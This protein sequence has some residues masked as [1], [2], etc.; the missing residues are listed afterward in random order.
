MQS[1]LACLTEIYPDAIPCLLQAKEVC[2]RHYLDY[3]GACVDL[4][5]AHVQF[6]M[7][8]GEKAVGMLRKCLPHIFAHGGLF[9]T[10]RAKV[11]LAKILVANSQR[12]E[13]SKRSE[14][15]QSIGLLR[16]AADGYSL[17]K[18]H[19]RTRDALYI[20]ARLYNHLELYEER[21]QVAA[22]FKA[23]EQQNPAD[24]ATLS[25]MAIVL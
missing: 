8:M 16:Q 17:L 2:T 1:E 12:Q 23:N 18:A 5:L 3:L 13:C 25:T 4:H 10:C 7:D 15:H 6:Q 21:N 14:L 24:A 22:E 11:L 9:E 20:I 19:S